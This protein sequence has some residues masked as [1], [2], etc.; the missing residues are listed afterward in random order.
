MNERRIVRVRLLRLW[1]VL[2]VIGVGAGAGVGRAVA[3]EWP[4]DQRYV[5]VDRPRA[6]FYPPPSAVGEDAD[7][8]L[9]VLMYWPVIRISGGSIAEWPRTRLVRIAPDG[10]EF[11]VRPIGELV[12]GSSE[13]RINAD[14]EILPLPDGSILFSRFNAIDRLRPEGSIVR[15][16]GTG[17]Y[18][19]VSSGDGGPATVADI[20]LIRGLSRFADGSIVFVDRSRIRRVAPDAIITTLAG[21]GENGFRG[22]GGPATAAR[23]SRPS[24]V[25]ATEDGGFLIADTFSN[26]ARRV[27]PTGVISTQIRGLK[28]PK[29]L[30]R[31]PDGSLLVGGSHRIRQVSPSGTIRTVLRIPERRANR[32]GDFAGRHGETIEAMGV[33]REG[34]VMVIVSDFRA[35]YL[36]PSHTRRLLVA[37]RDVRASQRRVEV[38]VDATR[39]GSLQLQLRRRG[40]VI[41][42][43]TRRIRVGRHVIAA[44]GRF[45]AA[46]H[47]VQVTLRGKRGGS[48]RD[49]VRL[50]TSQTLPT[51]LVRSGPGRHLRACKR[52]DRRRIDCASHEP[53]AYEDGHAC[54]NTS[55]YRLFPSGILFTRPYGPRYHHKPIPFDREPK[56]SGPWR[57]RVSQPRPQPAMRQRTPRP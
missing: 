52:L 1:L 55:A 48:H 51:R 37:L 31:L 42:T 44:T 54:L 41:V 25:L 53:G 32:L 2:L 49:R 5:L 16:A 23:L 8:A 43:M 10:R 50:F 56:W 39:R 28:Q 9:L 29:Y 17:R 27:S 33:T 14:D 20:G 47:D 13:M 15:F 7:G 3:V 45:A 57:R 40:R 6:G 36:A 24:D 11:F 30:D 26:R 34:G 35:Y 19:V 22:D 4:E 38:N 21:S 18:S 12:P 46:Y